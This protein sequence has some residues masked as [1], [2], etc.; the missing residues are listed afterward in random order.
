MINN[1][2][3]LKQIQPE[4]GESSSGSE[5]NL[6]LYDKNLS[7][8]NKKDRKRIKRD[9]KINADFSKITRFLKKLHI[10]SSEIARNKD[11]SISLVIYSFIKDKRVKSDMN[12]VFSDLSDVLKECSEYAQK[13]Q[14]PFH[15]GISIDINS[16]IHKELVKKLF[17]YGSF[18]IK[19]Q[20][21]NSLAININDDEFSFNKENGDIAVIHHCDLYRKCYWIDPRVPFNVVPVIIGSNLKRLS[22]SLIYTHHR[23]KVANMTK[24]FKFSIQASI[25]DKIQ[26]KRVSLALDLY[27]VSGIFHDLCGVLSHDATVDFSRSLYIPRSIGK[28]NFQEAKLNVWTYFDSGFDEFQLDSK[29]LTRALF[30]ALKIELAGIETSK[31]LSVS[32]CEII[33]LLAKSPIK[34]VSIQGNWATQHTGRDAKLLLNFFNKLIKKKKDFVR[35]AI[36]ESIEGV[37]EDGYYD[38]LGIFDNSYSR[39]VVHLMHEYEV[40]RFLEEEYEYEVLEEEDL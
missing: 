12:I 15:L 13:Y 7:S 23:I 31:H 20:D 3:N 28:W 27:F 33:S 4:N 30:S 38:K 22:F 21:L 6:N 16:N 5:E 10:D 37:E 29:Y 32:T 24:M 39:T 40:D 34:D 8:S 18:A 14:K 25:K 2:I 17:V 36:G 19:A 26:I 11:N 9:L 35:M 1:E